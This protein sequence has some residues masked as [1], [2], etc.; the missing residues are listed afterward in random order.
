M[1]AV[2]DEALYLSAIR[3]GLP[4]WTAVETSTGETDEEFRKRAFE[5]PPGRQ[6]GGSLHSVTFSRMGDFMATVWSDGEIRVYRGRGVFNTLPPIGQNPLRRLV[7]FAH[8]SGVAYGRDGIIAATDGDRIIKLK[9]LMR[10]GPGATLEAPYGGGPIQ[11]IWFTEDNLNVVVSAR[12]DRY[13]RILRVPGGPP[14]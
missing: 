14:P 10:S 1:A 8:D 4:T 9:W 11:S 12:G 6:R 3:N 7:A 5:S 2:S 13:L